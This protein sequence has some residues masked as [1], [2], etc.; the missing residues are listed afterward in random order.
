MEGEEGAG[1]QK[2]KGR[3]TGRKKGRSRH[4]WGKGKKEQPEGRERAGRG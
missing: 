2:D 4:A 1:R 3:S